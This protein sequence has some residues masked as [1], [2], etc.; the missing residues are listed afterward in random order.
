MSNVGQLIKNKRESLGWSQKKLGL[1][2]GLSDSEIMKIENGTRKKPNW[3]NLC[4]IAQALDSHPFEL[5]L[6]AGYI[7]DSDVHPILLLKG[8]TKLSKQ[9]IKYLQLFID[10]MI[11]RKNES[12]K[13]GISSCCLD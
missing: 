10:F 4:R 1:A 3:T 2:A 6:A 5:M 9:E 12:T 8:L 11:S 7:S 13:E